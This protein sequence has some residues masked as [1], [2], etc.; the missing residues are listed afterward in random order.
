MTSQL[1]LD[2]RSTQLRTFGVLLLLGIVCLTLLFT[3][4]D[5]MR[6]GASGASMNWMRSLEINAL[7]WGT[8][9]ALVPLIALVGRPHRLDRA[10]NRIG[11]IGVWALIGATSCVTQSVITG[12]VMYQVGLANFPP[13][14]IVR[15]PLDRYLVNWIISTFG[16]N[17]IIF[18][19]IVGA[20]HAALYYRDLRERQLREIDLSARLARAELNVLRM[21]LQPH[22]FFN[23]LHTVSSLMLSDVPT[24][25]RVITALG[26]LLRSSIDHTAHQEITLREE[27]A[28]VAR[29][30][31]IQQARFRNRLHVHVDVPES[32]LDAL[33]PSLVL[34]PL[35]ENAIRH[36]IEPSTSGGAIWIRASTRDGLLAL[37][38]RDDGPSKTTTD[39]RQNGGPRSI[40]GIGLANIEAR[41]SQLYG[42]AQD[43]RAGRSADGHYDVTL[44][45]PLHRELGI[46]PAG[47]GAS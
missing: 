37:S 33:V 47:I 24:A 8:W 36:G 28:F 20:F 1:P 38:V 7:D 26:D 40:S 25:H 11:R 6:R 17:M 10:G 30:V 34:Q 2:R 4:Q 29:Y 13:Q 23:A 31:E 42:A 21:Q 41:L 16:F 27:L 19:M 44:T 14:L 3:V 22:F 45:L 43:F 39:D 18:L 5:A 35:V 46:F 12:V 32:T 9:G 15:P